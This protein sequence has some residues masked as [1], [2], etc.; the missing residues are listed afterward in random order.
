MNLEKT[1]YPSRQNLALLGFT[2]YGVNN[3]ESYEK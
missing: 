1:Q 2:N 3:Y